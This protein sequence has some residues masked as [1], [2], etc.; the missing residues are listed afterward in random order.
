MTNA[1]TAIRG[2][3]D[4]L[5]KEARLWRFI[6]ET[7]L[8]V[9]RGYGFEEIRLPIV[10]K[11]ELFCRTIGETTDIVEKQMYTF[12]D[13]HG[14]SLSLRPEGTATAVRA[15][16]E[17]RLDL[18]TPVNKLFYS[19]PMFRYER[20]QKGR[21]RQFYQLGAEVLGEASARI[22]AELIAMLNE[23]FLEL[24]VKGIDIEINTLGCRDCRGA[25]RDA[26]LDF[27]SIKK[28]ALCDNCKRR[29]IR[30][31]L[32]ALDCKAAGCIEATHEAPTIDN[33]LCECCKDHFTE[34]K[35][36]LEL[37]GVRYKINPRM[38]RGLD[39]YSRTAFEV[40]ALSTSEGGV[41]GSQNSI[42]AGGRYD[43]LVGELGG[44]DTP[45]VGFAI[46]ME[47]L[48]MLIEKELVKTVPLTYIVVMDDDG[49]KEGARV[50]ALIRGEGVRVI[51]DYKGGKLKSLMKRAHKSNA[52]FV[53]IIGE[54]ELS[55]G[56]LTLKVM[57]TG[58]QFGLKTESLLEKIAV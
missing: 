38:V 40:T 50:A 19:G 8:R 7:A 29:M 23:F 51:V 14:D 30:N 49:Y 18:E 13:L 43:S 4:I 22:D 48:A 37:L 56:L 17:N 3:N 25:Y 12:E 24:G 5:P 58:E 31:P 53:I 54:D 1:I 33:Y 34:L 15:Y 35:D 27:L 55:S 52:D 20:P 47:R 44:S 32:R 36:T 41:L 26:L 11:T 21:Y 2:F 16:V 42:A 9:F 57:A 46:G 39:Y 45:C 28:E 10:E 6:E